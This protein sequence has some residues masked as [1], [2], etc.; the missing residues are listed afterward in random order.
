MPASHGTFV[1]TLLVTRST[2]GA[3]EIPKSRP[4]PFYR[5]ARPGRFWYYA[6]RPGDARSDLG[7]PQMPVGPD[8]GAPEDPLVAAADVKAIRLGHPSYVWRS[9]QDRRLTQIR[10]Y[11]PLEKQRILDIGCGLGMYV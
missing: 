6:L 9:G 8:E 1:Q 10:R 3:A 5:L 11:V 2:G 4:G 7:H